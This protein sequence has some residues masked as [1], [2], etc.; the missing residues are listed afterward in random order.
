M[1]SDESDACCLPYLCCVFLFPCVGHKRVSTLLIF[2]LSFQFRYNLD[3]V[4]F[5]GLK[6]HDLR[7]SENFLKSI[8]MLP[9]IFSLL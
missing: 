1:S 2:R 3:E 6:G 8:A 9:F 7:K 4:Y 5:L